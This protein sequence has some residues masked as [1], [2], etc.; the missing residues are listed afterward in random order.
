MGEK[1][2]KRNYVIIFNASEDTFED[3]LLY[4]H[5]DLREFLL[6][7]QALV[8]VL[9]GAVGVRT[10]FL[11]KDMSFNN[12]FAIKDGNLSSMSS[13]DSIFPGIAHFLHFKIE[14]EIEAHK[15]FS[16]GFN[17]A[18]IKAVNLYN[19]GVSN[20]DSKFRMFAVLKKRGILTP[21][22]K[23]I[24]RFNEKK[25]ASFENIAETF[26]PHGFYVQPDRGTEGRDCQ[27]YKNS[28]YAKT[29][30]FLNSTNEDV[31][32]RRKTG[33]LNYIKNNFVLRIN[34]SFDGREFHADSGFA[35]V[36]KSVVS[37]DNG[38]KKEDIN[39]VLN[40]LELRNKE[41]QKIKEVSC[42]AVKMIFKHT[43]PPLIIGAD[44]VLERRNKELIPYI[45]DLNP[46][47][48]VVGSRIIGKDKL[49]LGENFWKGVF[50][51]CA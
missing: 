4:F 20:C 47:P 23:L 40:Y 1:I 43:E 51:R 50:G 2:Q 13:K 15:Q 14:N 33:N 16:A 5:N 19:E 28:E 26:S 39:K 18:G 46:R 25:V 37:A 11:N 29:V 27:L 6:K 17:G 49:N 10:N 12:Y 42:Q 45:I 34:V 21:E 41:I 31:I 44:L 9:S 3:T 22:A 36:G 7:N 38:A 32:I 35:M 48:V 24:S 30:Q 8:S